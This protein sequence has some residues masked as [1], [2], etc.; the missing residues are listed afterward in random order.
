MKTL[1]YFMALPT[2][3]VAL[4]FLF[5]TLTGTAKGYSS[6][7]EKLATIV[8]SLIALGLVGWAFYLNNTPDGTGYGVGMVV[9]S[10]FVFVVMML[11]NGL[12]NTKNWN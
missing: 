4:L 12:L 10:W 8:A 3:L 6:L 11:A 9:L 2:V 1:F 7:S 5:K